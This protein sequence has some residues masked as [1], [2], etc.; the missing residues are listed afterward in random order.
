MLCEEMIW[1]ELLRTRQR[2]F[3]MV[4]PSTSMSKMRSTRLWD[5]HTN[6]LHQMPS[7]L[8]GSALE[9]E[10]CRPGRKKEASG[11]LCLPEGE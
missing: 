4:S 10:I 2:P 7:Q 9:E 11:G 1:E 5:G 8:K 6:E 3:N